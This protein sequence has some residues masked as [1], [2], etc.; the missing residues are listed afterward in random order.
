[1]PDIG[2]P[3]PQTA[4]QAVPAD[5]HALAQVEKWLAVTREV[6]A[7]P[8]DDRAAADNVPIAREDR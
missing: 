3:G 2:P 6:S 5:V 4:T 7:R 8:G 1:M